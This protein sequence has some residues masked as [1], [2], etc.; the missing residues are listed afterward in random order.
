MHLL[1]L[2]IRD[3]SESQPDAPDLPLKLSLSSNKQNIAMV[4]DLNKMPPDA[5]R[6]TLSVHILPDVDGKK[7]ID[8]SKDVDH[9]KHNSI[10]GKCYR[11]RIN[12]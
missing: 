6:P 7:S 4:Q 11:I 9:N 10:K 2:L 1:G 8:D 12:I 5:V 3:D